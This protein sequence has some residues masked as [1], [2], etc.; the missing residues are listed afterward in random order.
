MTYSKKHQSVIAYLRTVESATTMEIYNNVPFGYFHNANKHMGA[1][2]ATMVA[3]GKIQRIAPGR[4]ALSDTL[5]EAL[6][7][8]LFTTQNTDQP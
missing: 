8:N 6:Q 7:G 3:Q 4:F 1:L 2:L 5:K